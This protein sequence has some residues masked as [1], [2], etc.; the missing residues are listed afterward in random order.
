MTVVLGSEI[1]AGVLTVSEHDIIVVVGATFFSSKL[2][3]PLI[4]EISI[5]RRT[6]I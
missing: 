2:M 1:D 5:L 6:R 3:K 4:H